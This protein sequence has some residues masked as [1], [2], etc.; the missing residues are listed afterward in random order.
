MNVSENSYHDT[1][2]SIKPFLNAPI[3]FL[4]YKTYSKK[5]VVIFTCF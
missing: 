3:S 5:L 1:Y 4:Y 2:I